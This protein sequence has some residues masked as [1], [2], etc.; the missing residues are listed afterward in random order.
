[1]IHLYMIS[2]ISILFSTHTLQIPRKHS[3][4]AANKCQKCYHLW[5][6]GVQG[7]P[8]LTRGMLNETVPNISIKHMRRISISPISDCDL[9]GFEQ[10]QTRDLAGI[11]A[12]CQRL[13]ALY[14]AFTFPQKKLEHSHCGHVQMNCRCPGTNPQKSRL[15]FQLVAR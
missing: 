5:R 15:S 3:H 10:V 7:I 13:M 8:Y 9:S 4:E 12:T 6:P 2:Y 1:M 11:T 14:T